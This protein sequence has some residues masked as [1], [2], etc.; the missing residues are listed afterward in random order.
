MRNSSGLGLG[1]ATSMVV[2]RGPC[3]TNQDG[4]QFLYRAT[5]MPKTTVVGTP[6]ALTQ[7]HELT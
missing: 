5:E 3:R 2:D 6:F 1:H 7:V 4:K